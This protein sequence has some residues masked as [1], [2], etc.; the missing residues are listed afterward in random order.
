MQPSGADAIFIRAMPYACTKRIITLSRHFS[1][2][3]NN[4]DFMDDGGHGEDQIRAA[5]AATEASRDEK[6]VQRRE[7]DPNFRECP[8]PRSRW[9]S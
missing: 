5:A 7:A 8:S 9:S 3:E 1:L 4:G 2:A 6:R